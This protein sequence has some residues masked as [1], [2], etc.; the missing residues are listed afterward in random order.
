M[1]YE[2]WKDLKPLESPVPVG[3]KCVVINGDGISNCGHV[4]FAMQQD[5]FP[6]CFSHDGFTSCIKISHLAILPN[7]VTDEYAEWR[8][9]E[10][11]DCAKRLYASSEF[12]SA[13]SAIEGAENLMA[14]FEKRYGKCE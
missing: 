2:N 8:K 5:F 7:A 9:R 3:T 12:G 14:E 10:V 6:Q 4:V 11:W 13:A 1:R